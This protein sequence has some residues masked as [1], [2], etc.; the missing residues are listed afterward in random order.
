MAICVYLC[1][2]GLTPISKPDIVFVPSRYIPNRH[3]MVCLAGFASLGYS[4]AP[5]HLNSHKSLIFPPRA[6]RQRHALLRS[7]A[8]LNDLAIAPTTISAS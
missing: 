8:G 7:S 1:L 2:F 6:S 4:D 3:R 5:F